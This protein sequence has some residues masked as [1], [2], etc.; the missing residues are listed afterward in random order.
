VLK[1]GWSGLYIPRCF[2]R[3]VVPPSFAGMLTQRHRWCFGAMQILRLH[4]RSLMPWDRSPD[5]HLTA[6]QRRDYLMASLSWF[7]DLV[8]LAFS[9][10][11]MAVTGLLVTHSSFAVAPLDGARSV[12]PLSFIL[13]ATICMVFTLRNWTSLSYRRAVLSLVISLSVTWVIALGCIE[14]LARR[15]GVFLRTSKAGGRRTILTALRLARVETILAAV[16]FACAAL[17]AGFR[18]GPWLLIALI[19]V[20][21]GV[22]L[23]GPIASVWNLRA[24]TVPGRVRLGVQ[25]RRRAR[26]LPFPG[27]AA[28]GLAALCVGGATSAFVAPASLLHANRSHRQ[29]ASAQA[30]GSSEVYLKLGSSYQAV[31]SAHLSNLTLSFRTSSPVLLGEILRAS[32]HGGRIAQVG[33]A[34]RTGHE[35][36]VETFDAATVTSVREGL[37]GT[38]TGSVSLQLSPASRGTSA[39]PA[40]VAASAPST[41]RAS[42]TVGR[43]APSYAV[44]AVSFTQSRAGGPLRLSFTTSARP[45]LDQLFRARGARVSTLTLSVR[46]GNGAGVVRQAFYRLRVRSLTQRGAG[47]LSGTVTLVAPPR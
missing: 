38:P 27:P 19:V 11:L 34:S 5:N 7:R 2:G 3:G 36:R 18:H 15:D 37:S 45:L 26:W 46:D 44:T 17:L 28:A 35:Q 10:L 40:A 23:C 42:V 13:I 8:M 29:A 33:L 30:S 6:A 47:S 14:G 43:G 4:W 9:L 21:A 20:Q 22:Y 39:G 41:A 32:A 16:L 1:D 12:L 31:A 24:R 25:R